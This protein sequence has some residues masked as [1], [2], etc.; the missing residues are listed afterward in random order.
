MNLQAI[1]VLDTSADGCVSGYYL[2]RQDGRDIVHRFN[3][4]TLPWVTKE[5]EL[6]LGPNPTVYRV[7]SPSPILAIRWATSSRS[8]L[9]PPSVIDSA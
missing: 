7:S 3:H 2:S 9:L 1:Y 4:C 5:A 8:S 6:V